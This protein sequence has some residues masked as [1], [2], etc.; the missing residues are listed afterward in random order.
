MD[1]ALFEKMEHAVW[2]A[3]MSRSCPLPT[4]IAGKEEIRSRVK[5]VLGIETI[6]PPEVEMTRLAVQHFE[7]VTVETWRFRSWD[8]MYGDASLW[9]P[10]HISG[11]LPAVLFH[12]G[13][14]MEEGRFC[15]SYQSMSRLLSANGMAVLVFDVTGCGGRTQ[16]GHRADFRPFLCG[17]TVCGLM[18]LEAMG[19][20]K[21]LCEDPRIDSARCGLMGHSGGGQNTVFLTALLWD[22][23]AFAVSSGFVCGFEF[24]ARKERHLCECNLFPGVLREFE[25]YHALGCIAPK[26]LMISSGYGDPMIPR[27]YA[28]AYGHRLASLWP[29]DRKDAFSAYLWEGGHSWREPAEFA[30]VGNFALRAAGLPEVKLDTVPA[31][32]FP[33]EP[34][35]SAPPFPEDAINIG[36]LAQ[37]LTGKTVPETTLLTDAFP[38]PD[39]VPPEVFS[40]LDA[41]TQEYIT[42]SQ[43]FISGKT[44]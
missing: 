9:L 42:Q 12:H 31:P 14:A 25:M 20:F 34:D 39:C 27:D 7:D 40:K 6:S 17:T 11:P 35:L 19:L 22:K 33:A 23:L 36:I 28:L 32:A 1:I 3:C 21:A 5:R 15:G 18:C 2:Q 30:E 43:V 13:H 41:E 44:R 24:G 10:A 8:G 26:P 38:P 37:R 29:E 4:D 16:F